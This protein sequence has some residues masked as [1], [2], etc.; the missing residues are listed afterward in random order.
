MPFGR[1]GSGSERVTLQEPESAADPA[2]ASGADGVR[3]CG[4]V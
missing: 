4:S 3:G 2:I 1:G